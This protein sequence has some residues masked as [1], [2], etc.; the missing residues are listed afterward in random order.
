MK[1]TFFKRLSM[2][3]AMMTVL[4]LMG[5]VNNIQA[6]I[7]FMNPVPN[8]N[9]D[10]EN[11]GPKR[12]PQ[13]DLLPLVSYEEDLEELCFVAN[14]TVVFTYEITDASGTLADVSTATC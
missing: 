5:H 3:A 10:W 7:V 8:D 9:G 1:L 6:G 13:Q 2:A 12:T 14:N 4:P 11:D